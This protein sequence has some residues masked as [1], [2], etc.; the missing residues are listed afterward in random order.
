MDLMRHVMENDLDELHRRDVRLRII[1]D[2]S[3][4]ADDIQRKMRE[5]ETLTENNAKLNLAVAVNFGGRWD[6][7]QAARNL[8]AQAQAG[9]IDP[10]AIDEQDFAAATSL[11][12]L[13]DPDLLIRTGGDYRVS[14][15]LLWHLAYT[16]LYFTDAFWPDFD[17]DHLRQAMDAFAQR[18]RRFGR[19]S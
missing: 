17:A 12:G 19:R 15:F 3:R 13:P 18:V 11:R 14:N 9:E 7:I 5:C 16:E 6:I 8:A 4:F 10:R 1:G 2:R